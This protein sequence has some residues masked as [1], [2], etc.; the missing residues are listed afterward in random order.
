MQSIMATGLQ[1]FSQANARMS[2]AADRMVRASAPAD[3]PAAHASPTE[4]AENWID[5]LIEA[6]LDMIKAHHQAAAAAASIRSASDQVGALLDV[7]A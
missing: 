1:A 6:R 2:A 5:A 3:R 7:K 4:R